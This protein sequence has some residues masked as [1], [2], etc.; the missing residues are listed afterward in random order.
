MQETSGR[1]HRRP[2]F[3]AQVVGIVLLLQ[4]ALLRVIATADTNYVSFFGYQL[5]WVCWFK[6]LTG[7]PCPTCGMSRSVILTLHGYWGQAFQMNAA[8]PPAVMG[9]LLFA[10]GLLLLPIWQRSA[11]PESISLLQNR[12]KQG[13]LIYASVLVIVLAA[14]WISELLV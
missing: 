9:L 7:K 2:G 14:N 12:F 8:G 4:L 1:R 13:S 5:H 10:V 3:S 6:Q 11:T